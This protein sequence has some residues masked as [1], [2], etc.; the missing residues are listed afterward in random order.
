MSIMEFLT[1]NLLGN[2]VM[3]PQIGK[4]VIRDYISS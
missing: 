1:K 4:N 3:D 2:A